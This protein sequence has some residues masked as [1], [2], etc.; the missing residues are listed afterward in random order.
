MWFCNL[1]PWEVPYMIKNWWWC[2]L[3]T[4][5]EKCVKDNKIIMKDEY[6]DYHYFILKWTSPENKIYVEDNSASE[7]MVTCIDSF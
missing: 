3:W 5:W 1:L 7:W 6:W 4:D 2:V